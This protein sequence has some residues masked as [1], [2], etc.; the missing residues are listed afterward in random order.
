MKNMSE[1]IENKNNSSNVYFTEYEIQEHKTEKKS[2][3]TEYDLAVANMNKVNNNNNNNNN[4]EK[5][6]HVN[7]E[8][9]YNDER[10]P[11]LSSASESSDEEYEYKKGTLKMPRV[12]IQFLI[13]DF[14]PIN[15]IDTVGVKTIR[16]VSYN[17]ILTFFPP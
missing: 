6:D 16:Q 13:I 9:E 11:E 14:S 5:R 1:E 3:L 7:L 17:I 8:M 15:F 2:S 4:D 10:V 12:G